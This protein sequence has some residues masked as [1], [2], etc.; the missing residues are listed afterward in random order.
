MKLKDLRVRGQVTLVEIWGA[1]VTLRPVIRDRATIRISDIP[2]GR[3][4]KV[5]DVIE[6]VILEKHKHT[7]ELIL[8]MLGV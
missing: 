3:E 2:K 8:S 4:L 6:C 1:F 5:G 7:G